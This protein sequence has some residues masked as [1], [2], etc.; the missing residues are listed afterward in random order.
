MLRTPRPLIQISVLLLVLGIGNVWI[1]YSKRAYYRGAVIQATEETGSNLS[2]RKEITIKRL[3]SRAEY[4]RLVQWGG[5][6][7]LTLAAL[8]AGL[9]L[10]KRRRGEIIR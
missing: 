6:G 8:L 2:Y 10:N 1:G 7:F 5:V 4:Y 9:D 3:Q